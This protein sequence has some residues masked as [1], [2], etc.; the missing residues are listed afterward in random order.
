VLTKLE[1][2][3]AYAS[4]LQIG[5]YDLKE[6][7]VFKGPTYTI[8]PPSMPSY[9]TPRKVEPM[10]PTYAQRMGYTPITQPQDS[11]VTFMMKQVSF[12]GIVGLS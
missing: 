2:L 9:A 10:V 5:K 11:I 6:Q 3:T 7:I 4:K 8:D 1:L 12:N